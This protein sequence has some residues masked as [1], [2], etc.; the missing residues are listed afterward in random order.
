MEFRLSYYVIIFIILFSLT[1]CDKREKSYY[2]DGNLKSTYCLNSK[3][4]KEG[5]E[6]MFYPTGELQSIV[7]YKDG[8]WTDSIVKYNK[9]G[10]YQ[11]IL[12]NKE[13]GLYLKA[14]ENNILANE[15]AVDDDLN[16]IGWWSFYENG[17]LFSKKETIIAEGNNVTN[18][19]LFYKNNELISNKSKYYEFIAPDE[20]EKQKQYEFKIN[21]QFND[22]SPQENLL[23]KD[24][25]YLTFSTGYNEDF[26]NSLSVKADTLVPHKE[27]EFLINLGFRN[28]GKKN[29]RAIIER[30]TLNKK[31]DDDDNLYLKTAKM[32]INED[33]EVN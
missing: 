19:E 14:F 16:P 21:F 4:H 26:S 7:Y 22:Y 5:K 25:Y 17:N 12:Y 11:S 18:Q 33:I 13:D 29:F 31:E 3:N 10:T 28:S 27:N 23:G 15:G 8:V 30:R 32:Y 24:Y 20:V 2:D 6:E 9:D 1:S